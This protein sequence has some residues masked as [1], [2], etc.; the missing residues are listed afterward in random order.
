MNFKNL[1]TNGSDFICKNAPSIL[2][3]ISIVGAIS[4]VGLASVAAIQSYKDIEGNDLTNLEKA[5]IIGINYIPTIIMTSTTIFC[6]IESHK[7]DMRRE[8][9]FAT[10]YSATKL[11]Y[12]NFKEHAVEAIGEKKVKKIDEKVRTDNVSKTKVPTSDQMPL[13]IEGRGNHLFFDNY[14]GQYFRSDVESIRKCINNINS[15][16]RTEMYM[17][18]NDFYSYLAEVSSTPLNKAK[19]GNELGWNVDNFPIDVDISTACIAPN[20]EP[21]IILDFDTPPKPEFDYFHY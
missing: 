15:D 13:I 6:S 17:S 14:L 2:T 1:I 12:D 16:L 11:A 10:A 20:G 9:A 7:I 4:S 21:C 18:L 3:G 5:K 8:A 19:A